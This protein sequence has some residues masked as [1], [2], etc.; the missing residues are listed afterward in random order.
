MRIAALLALVIA[1]A[2]P[3]A[4]AT[5][6]NLQASRDTA[7]IWGIGSNRGNEAHMTENWFGEGV[8]QF[9]LVQFELGAYLGKTATSATLNLYADYNAWRPGQNYSVSQNLGAW[10]E[11]TTMYSNAPAA[12]PVLASVSTIAGSR[13]YAF[14]VTG[15]VN[16]WLAGGANYGFTLTETNGTIYF[17]SRENQDPSLR[18]FLQLELQDAQVPEPASLALFGLGL[19]GAAAMRRRRQ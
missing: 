2:S 1:T 3:M 17:A 15:A 7:I 9:G 16:G 14:D 13:Y 10:D 11:Y 6:V 5:V 8:D 19:A 18:P 4:T 12:G